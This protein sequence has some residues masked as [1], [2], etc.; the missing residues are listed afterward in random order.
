[1]FKWHS[2]LHWRVIKEHLLLLTLLT[3]YTYASTST[4]KHTNDAKFIIK[5]KD[6]S[7]LTEIVRINL[8]SVLNRQS[9]RHLFL[10][11]L[12]QCVCSMNL[13]EILCFLRWNTSEN[14]NKSDN[15]SRQSKMKSK[16]KRKIKWEKR[17]IHSRINNMYRLPIGCHPIYIKYAFR[18]LLRLFGSEL[19]IVYIHPSNVINSKTFSFLKLQHSFTVQPFINQSIYILN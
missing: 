7:E 8:R 9:I 5:D 4:R 19:I 16:M 10:I 18:L 17:Y 3:E 15:K 13:M 1:M 11:I 6:E 2:I 12:T 14:I